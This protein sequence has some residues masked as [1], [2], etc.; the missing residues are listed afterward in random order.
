M[1]TSNLESDIAK[2]KEIG[3]NSA[4]FAYPFGEQ[5]IPMVYYLQK[6]DYHMAVT[7]QQGFVKPGDSPMKL[8]RL[9]VTSATKMHELL[10][11]KS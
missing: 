11:P 5:S 4:Y 1:D 10:Q 6:N 3:I 8:K 7:V 9:T 2:M